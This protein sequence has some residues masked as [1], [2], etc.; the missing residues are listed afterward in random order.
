VCAKGCGLFVCFPFFLFSKTGKQSLDKT[1]ATWW[2]DKQHWK[3]TQSDWKWV[4][5]N[6]WAKTVSLLKQP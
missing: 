5:R 1:Q 2:W 3:R 6:C 4:R